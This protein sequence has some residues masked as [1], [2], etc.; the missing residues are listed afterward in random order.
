[1]WAN[2]P[3]RT[4]CLRVYGATGV[5][6]EEHSGAGCVVAVTCVH[7][8]PD[9]SSVGEIPFWIALVALD[10]TKNVRVM[11]CSRGALAVGDTVTVESDGE[12]APYYL[13]SADP[14]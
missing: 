2:A 10:G 13:K 6:A 14:E 9:S 11:G 7:R 12:C 1:M 8:V 3:A 5:A 4:T